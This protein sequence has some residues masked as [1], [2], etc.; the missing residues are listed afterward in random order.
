MGAFE[1]AK[2]VI[3][4]LDRG[5]EGPMTEAEFRA[6]CE[7]ANRPLAAGIIANGVYLSPYMCCL[8]RIGDFDDRN[9]RRAREAGTVRNAR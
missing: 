9:R 6:V 8:L 5:E 2:G 4:R 7:V 3:E 1:L